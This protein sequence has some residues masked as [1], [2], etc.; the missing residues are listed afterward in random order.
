MGAPKSAQSQRFTVHAV[1]SAG[2]IL[3][4]ESYFS[5]ESARFAGRSLLSEAS[6]TFFK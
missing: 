5:V 1:K 6:T 3:L 2:S 4:T